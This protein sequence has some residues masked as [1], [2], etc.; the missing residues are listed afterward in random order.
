MTARIADCRSGTFT[1]DTFAARCTATTA[2][3]G[4]GMAARRDGDVIP[5]SRCFAGDAG[6]LRCNTGSVSWLLHRVRVGLLLIAGIITVA[7]WLVF[8]IAL[9]FTLNDEL[10]LSGLVVCLL[11]LALV[12][13]LSIASRPGRVTHRTRGGATLRSFLTTPRAVFV[14][15]WLSI[16]CAATWASES[17][18]DVSLPDVPAWALAGSFAVNLLTVA[19]GGFLGHHRAWGWVAGS[20]A[21]AATVAL[22]TS[23]AAYEEAGGDGPYWGIWFVF[24]LVHFGVALLVGVSCMAVARSV[25]SVG[26]GH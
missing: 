21:A 7:A 8:A 10:A 4:A 3:G 14:V 18:S 20:T 9:Q 11:G 17:F 19:W 22:L 12:G 24:L 25:A 13:V 26:A 2:C 6:R 16:I 15:V 5:T 23:M 1:K